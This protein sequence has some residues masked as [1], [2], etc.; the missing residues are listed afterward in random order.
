MTESVR[1]SPPI[2]SATIRHAW[3]AA[4][5]LAAGLPLGGE[6]V[7]PGQRNDLF[8]AHE[9]IYRFASKWAAACRILDAACGTGYGS[10]LLADCGARSVTG[11][12]SNRRRISFATRTFRAENLAFEVAD[13]EDLHF[14]AQSFDLVV[15]SNTLEHLRRPDRFLLQASRLLS[16]QGQLV[17]A[18]PPVLSDADLAVHVTNRAHVSNLSVREWRDLFV[19]GCWS[20]RYFSHRCARPLDF[21]ALRETDVEPA[22][23]RFLEEDVEDAYSDPPI[24]AVFVLARSG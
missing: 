15:S 1:S 6:A 24:T 3:S 16:E 23:F 7:W 20:W 8:V 12:D 11:I 22:D 13:C 4:R 10:F 2:L 19:E 9:S 21:R 14:P 17:V 18:V 5:K